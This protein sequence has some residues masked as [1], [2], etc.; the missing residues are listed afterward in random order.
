MEPDV[1]KVAKHVSGVFAACM[2]NSQVPLKHEPYRVAEAVLEI[3]SHGRLGEILNS[4][5]GHRSLVSA[6]GHSVSLGRPPEAG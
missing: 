5:N 4:S 6:G 2:G 1:G 3:A